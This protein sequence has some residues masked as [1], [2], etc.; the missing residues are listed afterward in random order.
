[1]I[2]INLVPVKEKKK[3]K[4]FLVVFSALSVLTVFVLIL[5]YI[6]IQ[7][8][9]VASELNRQIEEVKKESESYQDKINE[10]KDLESKEA[11]LESFRKIVRSI[12]ETQRKVLVGMDQVAL[13]LPDGVWITAINQGSGPD[14]NKFTIQGYSF[15]EENLRKF[16]K[17]ML[18]P[19]GLLKEVSIDE[20][21]L[22]ASV[23]NN[24][25]MRQ[26]VLVFRVLDQGT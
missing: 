4:E 20:K 16:S 12:A 10:V 19:T 17:N 18:R 23:G 24:K 25:Q 1:M 5:A 21:S 7:R 14:G 22:T 8:L 9:K 15:S 2:K 13:N 26:F 6:Y 11:N 3:R